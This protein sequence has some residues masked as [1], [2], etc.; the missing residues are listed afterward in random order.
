MA[1]FGEVPVAVRRLPAAPECHRRPR[2]AAAASL[3]KPSATTHSLMARIPLRS[4]AWHGDAD[5]ELAVPDAFGPDLRDLG[6]L[7]SGMPVIVNG[8]VVDAGRRRR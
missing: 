1:K 4:R 5:I 2:P 3:I 6:R 7:P 8:R